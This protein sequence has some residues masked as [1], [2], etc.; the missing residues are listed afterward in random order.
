MKGPLPVLPRIDATYDG[1]HTFRDILVKVQH[2]LVSA[3]IRCLFISSK[4]RRGKTGR[5][6]GSLHHVC[7]Q[8]PM[9]L[10]VHSTEHASRKPT[11]LAL[12][13]SAGGGEEEHVLLCTYEAI[14]GSFFSN[15]CPEPSLTGCSRESREFARRL[16]LHIDLYQ[17]VYLIFAIMSS[18]QC[19]L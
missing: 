6:R 17:S 8:K 5:R 16:R 10:F 3:R 12:K 2:V 15:I 13:K 19:K 9:H 18:Y 11:I 1:S 4:Q 7:G 14:F